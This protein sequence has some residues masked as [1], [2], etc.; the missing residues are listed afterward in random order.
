[1]IFPSGFADIGPA[2]SPIMMSESASAS[3]GPVSRAQVGAK[4][5]RRQEWD[6][7]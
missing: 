1:M 7:D 3:L 5:K 2:G 4:R 6:R